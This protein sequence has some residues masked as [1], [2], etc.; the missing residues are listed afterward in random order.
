ME[1]ISFKEVTFNRSVFFDDAQFYGQETSFDLVIKGQ[2]KTN[3]VRKQLDA[4]VRQVVFFGDALFPG[5][6]DS[7]I[8]DLI[9]DW[10]A[11]EPCP[12]SAVAVESFQQTIEE[13]RRRGWI[14][15]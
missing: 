14:R 12:V 4:G 8:T 5:G 15:E 6:N 9:A 2:D 1:G 11:S 10:D 13:L 7:V 3:A